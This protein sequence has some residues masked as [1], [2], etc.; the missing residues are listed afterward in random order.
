MKLRTVLVLFLLSFSSSSYAVSCI[1]A[2]N[3]L[4]FEACSEAR[5]SGYSGSNSGFMSELGRAW[6]DGARRSSMELTEM[7]SRGEL[8]WFENTMM[9][10]FYVLFVG[11]VAAM[12][13]STIVKI[14]LGLVFF[15]PFAIRFWEYD[16]IM[17]VLVF[18]ASFGLIGSYI[19][20]EEEKD[21]VQEDKVKETEAK[22]Q[23]RDFKFFKTVSKRR[24]QSYL[25]S[26]LKP[27]LINYAIEIGVSASEKDTK[28]QII[29]KLLLLNLNKMLKVELID[30]AKKQS[31]IVK[32]RD[33]KAQIIKKIIDIK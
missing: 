12:P 8:N 29:E 21:M 1:D 17:V 19:E 2:P 23:V 3:S 22:S 6:D 10:I 9:F 14:V 16:Y 27:D 28:K 24:Y 30:Y 15:I 31:T 25:N 33:T 26:M 32:S 5:A 7:K 18:M 11:S 13:K 4:A 20:Q